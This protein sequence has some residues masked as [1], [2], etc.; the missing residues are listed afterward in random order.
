M[1]QQGV[2]ATPSRPADKATVGYVA[3]RV[4]KKIVFQPYTDALPSSPSED[5]VVIRIK[6]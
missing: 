1:A 2:G 6:P 3:G 5:V 4:P